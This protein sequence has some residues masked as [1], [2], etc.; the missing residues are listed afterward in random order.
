MEKE[1]TPET[2]IQELI[3]GHWWLCNRTK[4]SLDEFVIKKGIDIFKFTLLELSMFSIEDLRK[5]GV[6]N[7]GICKKTLFELQTVL[8]LAGLSFKIVKKSE[9]GKEKD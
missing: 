6:K 2:T 9:N 3:N 7:T 8:K 1:V 4:R 5:G